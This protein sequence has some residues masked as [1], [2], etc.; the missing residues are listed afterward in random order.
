MAGAVAAQVSDLAWAGQRDAAIARASA[1]LGAAPLSTAERAELLGLR[2]E[3]LMAA[4]RF[5]DAALDAKEMLRL[6]D[7]SAAPALQAQALSLHALVLMRQGQPK[8]ALPSAQRAVTLAQ[9]LRSKPL[10]ATSLLRL[11]EVQM[12]TTEYAAAL[13]SAKRAVRCSEAAGDPVGTG[14]AHW[15]IGFTHSRQSNDALS[16]VA[17]E[18]AAALAREAGD[19]LGLGNALNVLSFS[20]KDIAQRIGMLQQAAQAFDR[21]GDALGRALVTGNL[22]LAFA[23]LGLYRHACR[24]G[25]EVVALCARMGAR[26][27]QALQLGGVIGWR[28]ALGDLDTVGTRWP[29]YDALVSALDEP[30]TQG[31]RVLRGAALALAMGD[32]TAAVRSL[33]GLLHE[34]RNAKSG[35][36]LAVLVPLCRARLAA[37][38]AAGALRASEEAAALHRARNFARP[39]FGHPQDLWW[40]HSCALAAAG[41]ADAAWDALQRAHSLL[42]DAVR[43][44]HDEGLRRSCLNKPQVNRDIVRAWLSEGARR[45][46]P[47]AQ[48]LAHL[49]L[50]S[51][52]AEPFRRLVDTGMRLN[53][54]HGAAQ[55]HEFLIDEV[56]E[57]S[58]A[59]RVLLVLQDGEALQVAGSLLPPGETA[60]ALLDAVTPWLDEA[61]RSRAVRL[62]H[63]PAGVEPVDQ[64]SCLVAPLIAQNRVLGF[65][66]A[67]IEGAFGRFH[68]QDRDLLGMLAAMAAVA[69]DNAMWAQD[70]ERKVEAR[71]RELSEAL[72]HQTA[73][74]DVL[75]VIGGSVADTA[76]VFDKILQSCEQL[77]SAS[78]F[79]LHLVNEAGQLD[80]A[81]MRFTA[82]TRAMIGE[83]N[84]AATEADLRSAYPAPLANTSAE[85]SFRAGAVIQSADVLN[86]PNAPASSRAIAQRTGRSFAFLC[87][88]LLWEGK[89]IG[90][91]SMQ[92]LELGPFRAQEHALLKTFADQAVIAIQNARLFNETK[93]ALEQ[94]K[95]SAEVLGVISSSVA[96]TQPVF[97][98]ILDS[99]Q[100]LFA[101]E[102]RPSS[103]WGRTGSCTCRAFRRLR[104][105]RRAHCVPQAAAGNGGAA[106]VPRRGA[107]LHRRCAGDEDLPQSMREVAQRA[108]NYSACWLPMLWEGRGIGTISITRAPNASHHREGEVLLKTF[109][110]QAVI[111][112]QNARLFNETKE[113]LEQQ[114]ASSEVLGVISSSPADL[115]PVFDAFWKAPRVCAMRTSAFSTCS[116]ATT[117]VPSRSAAQARNSR[118]GCW[119]EAPS[120]RSP[121]WRV[122]WPSVAHSM[123]PMPGRGRESSSV[124]RTR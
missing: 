8:A 52:L 124:I 41:R 11:G 81:R 122:Y 69:L 45:K 105:G 96:D 89:G 24:L 85:L 23:E 47:A 119:S 113:A 73:T 42:L 74:A 63:G 55:L 72:Q 102:P 14:R 68:A 40:W 26:M 78:M 22:S 114:T 108:G 44:V 121:R 93:E 118:N 110:D 7:E 95:A 64:R 28:I 123:S 32:A 50:E 53:E 3:S 34:A 38:D 111:A 57:L 19:S 100:R 65:I 107:G 16:R 117:A 87:A 104:R 71:T 80:V 92:R 49:N 116:R 9:R 109:A 20:C 61:R 54:L 13:T 75:Q 115:A 77:F 25:E 112:I 83:A 15:L 30:L 29:E 48:R 37:G 98:R 62:R 17:A 39:N 59:Q 18:R 1:A 94:Q 103:W 79:S 90:T 12:R 6:A 99:C 35:H 58:G 27:N 60:A 82:A 70:L 97:E 84:I 120:S 36:E 67:D 56:T 46:L 31:E 91:L 88:P 101:A 43:H 4:G 21:A 10:L 5:A 106:H 51:R 86:D 76:P 66:Y 33:H 2:A